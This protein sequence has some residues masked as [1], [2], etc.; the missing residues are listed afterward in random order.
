MK[1]L[2]VNADDFGWSRAVTDGI[3]RAHHTGILTST[4]VMMNLPGAAEAIDQARR[5][6]PRLGV[7]VHL[8]LTEGETLAPRD[9]VAAI[10]DRQGRMHRSPTALFRALRTGD[11]ALAAAERELEAQ[12]VRA[13]ECGL[14][15]S[16]LDSHKHVHLYPR[17]L[18]VVIGLA[19]KHGLRAIRTT[20]EVRVAGLSRHLPA[21]WGMKD[22][23]R[24]WLNAV[25]LRRWGLDGQRRVRQAGLVTTD[26]FFGVRVTGGV[27]PE[28]LE[29][30]L[31]MAPDGTGE[32][33]THPGLP[34]ASPERPTRLGDSR[35]RELAA[36]CDE[37]VRR[38]AEESGWTWATY[39]DLA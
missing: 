8:N 31:Q 27:S 20:P 12:I 19:R 15:P 39:K 25:V 3:L 16:H 5:E 29:L 28:V 32:L 9:Q 4:T 11:A 24:Q 22:R 34:E 10:L 6:A 17:L 21:D 1:R 23:F 37:R 7:G 30:M 38:A 26:W 35:P 2:I 36:L 33:M 14:E 18:P 13:R